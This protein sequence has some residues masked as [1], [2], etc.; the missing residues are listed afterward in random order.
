MSI[1]DSDRKKYAKVVEKF[2]SHL[3]V[4]KNVIFQGACFDK[5]VKLPKSI[6]HSPIWSDRDL[7]VRRSKGTNAKRS[8]R[9]GYSGHEHFPEA[10]NER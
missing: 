3:D 7:R 9:C 1:S 4:R 10:T 6:H 8:T 5:T 2:D